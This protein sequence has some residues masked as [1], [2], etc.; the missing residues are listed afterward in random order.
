MS[1]RVAPPARRHALLLHLLEAH[2][3]GRML[4]QRQRHNRRLV[5]V[6][7]VDAH[8]G[9]ARDGE[10]AQEL[11]LADARAWKE[12]RKSVHDR[13]HQLF[14]V[15]AHLLAELFGSVDHALLFDHL[16]LAG[17]PKEEGV[18]AGARGD[19]V[20]KPR[21][22]YG[23]CVR[24]APRVLLV[25]E[26]EREDESGRH[27]QLPPSSVFG[28]GEG[29]GDSEGEGEGEGKGE[30]EG[31][32]GSDDGGGDDGCGGVARAVS[33]AA[34]ES[35]ARGTSLPPEPSSMLATPRSATSK[36]SSSRRLSASGCTSR[37][38]ATWAYAVASGQSRSCMSSAMATVGERL[39]PFAQ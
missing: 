30:G 9:C 32:G 4:S 22:P 33:G 29:E 14:V 37:R 24:L 8:L 6:K 10:S 21:L 11:A 3:A 28:G 25:Q 35:R 20:V 13:A 12:A 26:E 18:L 17:A 23:L 16:K 36:R 19:V 31:E 38:L 39:E 2:R 7:A 1:E 27:E 15:L 34:L 5:L